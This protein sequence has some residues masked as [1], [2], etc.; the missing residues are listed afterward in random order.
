[1]RVL[2]ERET[3]RVERLARR[4]KIGEMLS[5][6][7][8]LPREFEV[9]RPLLLGSNNDFE[10]LVNGFTTRNRVIRAIMNLDEPFDPNLSLQT[11]LMARKRGEKTNVM[12]PIFRELRKGFGKVCLAEGLSRCKGSIIQA[13][14]LQKAA[15]KRHATDGHVYEFDPFNVRDSPSW[16]TRVGV[17]NATTITGFCEYHD[18]RLFAP[19]ENERFGAQPKQLFLHHYRAVCQ[20][21]YNRAY[22]AKIFQRAYP[23][24]EKLVEPRSLQ[25]IRDAITLNN[26]DLEELRQHKL[27]CELSLHAQDWSE[28]EGYGWMGTRVP[29]IF[30]SDFF[31]PGK[32]FKGSHVQNRKARSALGWMSLTVTAT[33]GFAVV[34]LTAERGS[35]VLRDLVSSLREAPSAH[36]TMVI[37]NLIFCQLENFI[38]LPSW[39]EPLPDGHKRLFANAFSS[40]YFPRELPLACDWGLTEMRS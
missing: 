7:E 28:V 8:S 18:N 38:I 27:Q 25:S 15:F 20:A 14:T 9:P 22:K 31:A 2:T 34:L 36:Q 35:L 24:A 10:I 33:D 17:N 30:A 32:D 21:F 23:E 3:R 6:F 1:M 11:T 40:R 12:V 26:V 13:H 29:D 4:T 16:P 19:I 5:F 37:V 39:W